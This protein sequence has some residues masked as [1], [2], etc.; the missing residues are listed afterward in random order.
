MVMH[1]T[2]QILQMW[3]IQCYHEN[4]VF[5]F[6]IPLKLNLTIVESKN[7]AAKKSEEKDNNGLTLLVG[8]K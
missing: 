2:V 5:C 1:V 6:V 4:L 7:R 8:H 3:Q